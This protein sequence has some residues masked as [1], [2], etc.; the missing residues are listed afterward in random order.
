MNITG[1]HNRS[2][3]L[4]PA[5][6][7]LTGCLA[8][9]L[10]AW[11]QDRSNQA[12]AAEQLQALALRAQERMIRRMRLYEFGLRGAHGAV[13]VAGND[14]ESLSRE[15]FQRFAR[16]QDVRRQYP[17]VVAF[18]FARR[19]P[20]AAE[21]DFLARMRQEGFADIRIRQ[22]QPHAGDRFVVQC[23]EP[24]EGNAAAVGHDIASE[25]RRRETIGQAIRSAQPRLTAPV[26]LVQTPNDPHQFV[27]LYLA[28]YRSVAPPEPA[29]RDAQAFG[30]V[31]A[32]LSMPELMRDLDDEDEAY[33]VALADVT[34]P[35]TPQPL[36][37]E[38]AWLAGDT[39]RVQGVV[40]DLYGRHW[41]LLVQ[42]LPAFEQRLNLRRPATVASAVALSSLLTALLLGA[43]LRASQREHTIQLQRAQMAAVV[44]TAHDA[45]VL[46]TPQGDIL[47]WN[48]AA[49]RLLG[50]TAAEA[51]GRNFVELA[52]P[53]AHRAQ[54]QAV[55]ARVQRGEE[56]PPFDTVRLDKHGAAVPVLLSVS[57]V[58]SASAG[59]VGGAAT[60]LRD[61]RV[62][63]AAQQQLRQSESQA[64]H[65]AALL[66]QLI[67]SA[68]D[69]IWTKDTA[70]RWVVVNS[71]AAAVLGR[72]RQELAGLRDRDLLPAEFA[73]K[74]EAQDRLIM[75]EGRTVRI[76][77]TLLDASHGQPR[78]FS[79]IKAPVRAPDGQIVGML[80]IAR[81]VT[82]RKA[83]EARLAGLNA[84][85]EEQVRERTAQLQETIEREQAIL[86][87][88]ASAIIATDLA[89]QVTSF[90]PA[91]ERM[92]RLREVQ[93]LGHSALAFFDAA[94][95]LEHAAELP[96]EV[97]DNA[98]ALPPQLRE[99]MRREPAQP[100][101]VRTEWTLVRADGTRF[102]G[103]LTISAL[104]DGR[105]QVVGLLGVLTDLGERRALEEQL[106]QRSIQAEAAS[107]AKSAF[108]THMSHELRTPL[109]A[110][111]GLSQL[112]RQ[113]RL[114]EDVGRFVGHIHDAGEQLLALVSDVL[115]LSRIEAGEMHL[116]AAPF[117]PL[118]L[119]GAVL[120]LLKP[121]ADAKGIA[122]VADVAP[123][124]PQRLVGDTLRLRQ[125]LLNLLSN[126]VKF[127]SS[128]SVTLRVVALARDAHMVLLRLDVI[129]T[130]IG[131]TAEQ[132]QRI[133][134]PFAQADSTITRRFGGSGL[135]LSIV[136]RLVDMMDGTIGVDS[137]PSRGST[138]SVKLPFLV[139]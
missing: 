22:N 110:V 53:P 83:A 91:A 71:A 69:P 7:V 136:Q 64:R 121:Q 86:S 96:Q 112:L 109:N 106:R 33:A 100:G 119:L 56:V 50:W 67:E 1:L 46:H 36:Y 34:E 95:L 65:T 49:E 9:A 99:A 23:I 94:E 114:P 84:T 38:P 131:I 120:S 39:A 41:Q 12:V 82:E 42:A 97:R 74:V 116:E 37:T 105:G 24:F 126:A 128:G 129:D 48:P 3:L 103:L 55:L 26:R 81:D 19:V 127:T 10:G 27:L 15:Q 30:V 124:V 107:R 101:K 104:R 32:S 59:G 138:F 117:E 72:P 40:L 52:V 44:D 79:S 88:A 139:A 85:L 62:Q 17:G 21:D 89:A 5:A 57:P 13:I 125:V 102:P 51:V 77:E 75:G 29:Q 16:S 31:T 61:M 25:A 93:A 133:F 47:S 43:R 35:G 20:P 111:I 78:V 87:S 92:L 54:T 63:Q 60:I 90:N 8:A 58:L 4:W 70:G 68:P 14:V 108:L 132:Q 137:Q 28:A 130:G 66:E 6:V 80:G 123:D 122:L 113:R 134:E 98:Q 18:A 45:I 115:D 73:E 11:W 135:G 76:E 118:P 2:V